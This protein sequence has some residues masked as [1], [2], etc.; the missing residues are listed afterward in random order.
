MVA[1]QASKYMATALGADGQKLFGLPKH[2]ALGKNM[3]VQHLRKEYLVERMRSMFV[4]SQLAVV[5]ATGNLNWSESYR[6]RKEVDKV[7]GVVTFTKNN[8][9]NVAM[10]KMIEIDGHENAMHMRPLFRGQTC[11]ITGPAEVPLAKSLL[12]LSK[13]LP[14]F[15]VLGAMLNKERLLQVCAHLRFLSS[16]LL[17]RAT[18]SLCLP[19]SLLQSNRR[20]AL[21]VTALSPLR[22][23][24]CRLPTFRK[25]PSC[26]L[27]ALSRPTWY[28]P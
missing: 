26:Q 9:A 15:Y 24:H 17:V 12:D 27:P 3:K 16:P 5:C 8:L 4:K 19:C 6:L 7:G 21:M 28:H 25:S 1:A 11:F 14:N 13:D 22:S 23:A 2:L 10:K 18:A 20:R